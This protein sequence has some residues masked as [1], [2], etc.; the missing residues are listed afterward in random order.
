MGKPIVLH[1]GD[2]IRWNHDVYAKF[3]EK[4]DIRRSYR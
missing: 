2:D 4:F 3:Q 1:L